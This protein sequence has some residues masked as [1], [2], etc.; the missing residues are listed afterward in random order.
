MFDRRA[1]PG[2]LA[3]LGG[4]AFAV[5]A[6]VTQEPV[7]V[8]LA[9]IC[10]ALC[11]VL[12]LTLP[13]RVPLRYKERKL[14]LEPEWLDVLDEYLA[15]YE[16]PD[17]LFT[18]TPRNLEYI[19]RDIGDAAG[20]DRGLLSFENLRWAAALR[21]WR[22]NAEQ[23]DIRQKLGLSKITWRETKSKLERLTES[24]EVEA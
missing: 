22:A 15:Q 20:L 4:L 2:T 7:L 17:T 5:A 23:D 11:V 12:V 3:G 9:A 8:I 1:L 24:E 21:D 6:I 16:P 13:N 10:T 18:C 19:L 14:D